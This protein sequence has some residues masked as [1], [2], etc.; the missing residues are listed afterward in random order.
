MRIIQS[1]L[2]IEFLPTVIIL[3]CLLSS[4]HNPN[5]FSLLIPIDEFKMSGRSRVVA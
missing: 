5:F 3:P 2:F 1:Y 4:Y